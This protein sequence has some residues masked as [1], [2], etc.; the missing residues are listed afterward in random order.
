MSKRAN[1]DQFPISQNKKSRSTKEGHAPNCVDD[2]CKGCDVGEVEISFVRK[3]ATGKTIDTEP[4]AQE[5]LA[6]A[7]DEAANQKYNDKDDNENNDMAHRLFDMA[8]EKYQKEEPDNHLGYATCLIELG[9]ALQVEESIREGLEVL[10]GEQKKQKGN[11]EILLKLA[12]AAIILANLLRK[13][14]DTYFEEQEAELKD[15]D[16]EIDEVAYEE[17]LQKQQ[18]SREEIKLYKDAINH[19]KEAFEDIEKEE[20]ESIQKEIQTVLHEL[21]AYGQLLTQP[22]HQ[23]HVNTVLDA[24]I[25]FIQ[26]LPK[27][28]EDADLLILWAACLLHKEKFIENEDEKL[29]VMKKI[30][31]MLIK[32]NKTHLLQHGKESAWVWEM[33]A[34]LRINQS[35]LAED[36]DKALDL[37]DE[38][39]KAF[40]K[41]HALDPDNPKL[42]EMVNMLEA[43]PEEEEE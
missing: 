11:K 34:M 33:Y 10:R 25:S 20:N 29:I 16:G 19:A 5:L 26:K 39:I 31:D 17:L 41:A 22:F 21:R 8:I 43:S 14:K 2:T 9:K 36:E 18:V 7:I 12:G 42:S 32:A 37:Y 4:N 23:I 35:N 38:A 3:D 27:Y 6:M 24:V 28:E 1:E 15:S 40:K 13:K 30:D